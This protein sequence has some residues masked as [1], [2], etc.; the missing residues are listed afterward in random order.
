[1]PTLNN[2]EVHVTT[3]DGAPLPE[4]RPRH[5]HN[6]NTIFCFIESKTNLPFY[7][8]L[9]PQHPPLPEP[10]TFLATL[11]LDNRPTPEKQLL[12]HTDPSDPR[13]VAQETFRHRYTRAADG[14]IVA[15]GW[16]FRDVGIE[17][18]LG[19]LGIAGDGEAVPVSREEELML[20]FGE[21]GEEREESR[22]AV[23]EVVV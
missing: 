23:I 7:I 8:T 5:L 17:D 18:L 14:R 3:R 13:F 4:Y 12:L 16:V 21:L 9:R 10:T 15:S 22:A 2:I 11:R 20:A 1:M 19:A 6:T